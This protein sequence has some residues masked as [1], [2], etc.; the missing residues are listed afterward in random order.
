M[1]DLSTVVDYLQRY[2]KLGYHLNDLVHK[3]HVHE[4]AIRYH[5]QEERMNTEREEAAKK[6]MGFVALSLGFVILIVI[7]FILLMKRQLEET[8][9]KNAVLAKEIADRIEYEEQYL[10]AVEKQADKQKPAPTDP[11]TLSDSDLFEYLRRIIMEENLH[12]NP[13]FD[14]QQL[15]DR[16][17]LSKDRIGA[18]FAQGSE[19]RSLKN[20]LNEIRLQHS[21]KLLAEH[22]GMSI[23]EVAAASGFASYVVF[24]RNFKQRFAITPTEFRERENGG[25][26]AE[27][28]E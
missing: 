25:L 14:W 22:P 3:S 19:Y 16:L 5:L 17:H 12:Q 2:V 9:K 15:I 21:A 23:N 10:A 6:R 7:F 27:N 18:A 13:L 20:F 1:G 11:S 8:R 26:E 4:Y 28:Y 24:A